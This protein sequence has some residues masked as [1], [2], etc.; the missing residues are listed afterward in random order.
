MEFTLTS[1]EVRVIGSLIEKQITTPEYYP[2]SLN[3]LISACNQLTNREPVVIYD[4]KIVSQALEMLRDKRLVRL[5][6]GA[7]AR[8]AKYDQALTDHFN[9]TRP[10][11]AVLCVLMLRGPQTVGELRG[12]SA[13]MYEFSGLQ[14]V[15]Y[16]LED[17]AN[18]TPDPLVV[19]L[20]RQP[21]TK[22]NRFAHLLSGPVATDPVEAKPFRDAALEAAR[23][24]LEND[25]VGILEREVQSL[26]AELDELKQ[27]FEAFR[28]QFE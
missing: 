18:L 14:Y 27:T 22:E 10:Q 21:G 20:P 19:K 17:L 8:V 1:V 7:D 9:L 6:S 24:E 2:L 28:K 12:R 16:A 5:V 13:R 3:A 26:R 23:V 25:R 4:E 11:T 15:E